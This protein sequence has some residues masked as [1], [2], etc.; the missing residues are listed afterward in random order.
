MLDVER[1]VFIHSENRNMVEG[2][3]FGRF[4][5]FLYFQKLIVVETATADNIVLER[6]LM[7]AEV[8]AFE[9]YI[10][11]FQFL[12]DSADFFIVYKVDEN[13]VGQFVIMYQTID[14]R[15]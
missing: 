14:V 10:E 8:K 7:E 9:F 4:Y 1:I 2:L 6:V 12:T 13:G 15:D 11:S 3:V 5:D